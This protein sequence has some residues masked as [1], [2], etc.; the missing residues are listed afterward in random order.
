MKFFVK[1]NASSPWQ[2]GRLLT[3]STNCA[4]LG[5]VLIGTKM[6]SQSA[7]N[8]PGDENTEFELALPTSARER[9]DPGYYTMEG[10][11]PSEPAHLGPLCKTEAT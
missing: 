3:L 5:G 4:L 8:L 7:E 10:G 6:A 2:E 9:R 11:P 1:L